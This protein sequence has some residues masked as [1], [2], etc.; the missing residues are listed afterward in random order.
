[1]TFTSQTPSD[2][3]LLLFGTIFTSLKH[4]AWFILTVHVRRYVDHSS[5]LPKEVVDSPLV[6][7][8]SRDIHSVGVIFLQMLLGHDVMNRFLTSTAALQSR[9]RPFYHPFSSSKFC[10]AASL[11]VG[12]VHH[13]NNMLSYSRKNGVTCSTLLGELADMSSYRSSATIT[14]PTGLFSRYTSFICDA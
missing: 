4:G 7:T 14:I 1:L 12:V 6:Y 13:I 2:L 5:R 8:R 3:T 9:M 11:P 10:L